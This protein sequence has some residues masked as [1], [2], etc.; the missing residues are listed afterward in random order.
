MMRRRAGEALPTMRLDK[1]QVAEF[2][3]QA[4]ARVKG[5]Q[6]TTDPEI[7]VSVE[8]LDDARTAPRR[9]SGVMPAVGSKR[10]LR[11]G[12]VPIIVASKED[13]AWFEFDDDAHAVLSRV[14]GKNTV[15]DI[16][17]SAVALPA[18]TL[19]VLQDLEL[20]RVIA[21]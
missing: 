19:E 5:A 7:E 3:K 8:Y 16:V 18:R 12:A 1:S 21:M 20:Q 13:L 14:D 6:R 17:T 10:G 2:A 15:A 9:Q 11:L 4:D